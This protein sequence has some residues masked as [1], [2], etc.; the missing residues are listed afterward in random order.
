MIK[1]CEMLDGNRFGFQLKDALGFVAHIVNQ[2][3]AQPGDMVYG[4]GVCEF[5][6][7]DS[8]KLT[9]PLKGQVKLG[10]EVM[11]VDKEGEPGLVQVGLEDAVYAIHGAT[12]ADIEYM[13]IAAAILS[14]ARAGLKKT[15]PIFTQDKVLFADLEILWEGAIGDRGIAAVGYNL[16]GQLGP[17][18]DF[19]DIGQVGT[20]FLNKDLTDMMGRV[21]G[22]FSG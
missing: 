17:F 13:V 9:G 3:G 10:K 1:I 8:P 4:Q 20:A 15:A 19:V 5:P 6:G 21:A 22:Y 2:Q 12:H 18:T 16:G 11:A 7:A 14:G